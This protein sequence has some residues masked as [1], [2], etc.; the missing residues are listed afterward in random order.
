MLAYLCVPASAQNSRVAIV[1]RSMILVDG[2]YADDPKAAEMLK[3]YKHV[4]DSVM[5]PVL[6]RT[7]KYMKAHAPES[8]LSNLLSDIMVWCGTKYNEKV[9]LGLYNLGGIRAAL[10][11]GV[12]TFGDVLDV[13]PFDNKICFVTLTGEQTRNLF[14]RL[15]KGHG[16]GISRGWVV[17]VENG[18]LASLKYEGREVEDGDNYRIATIDY[19]LTGSDG[20]RELRNAT[21]VNKPTDE[22]SNTRFLITDYFRDKTAKGEVVDAFIEGRVI[23]K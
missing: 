14:R 6:G 2:R 23:I 5:S 22:K 21:N 10:P 7:A 17:T 20:F 9:E 16:A 18:E 13:A 15:V 11:E 3:P 19:L 4:V 1:E 12:V 8:E